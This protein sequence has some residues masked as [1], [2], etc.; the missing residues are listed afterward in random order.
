M[1]VLDV[2]LQITCE[3]QIGDGDDFPTSLKW[4]VPCVGPRII[5]ILFSLEC[6][7]TGSKV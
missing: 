3:F 1:M 4:S 5:V 7:G 2:N 6:F